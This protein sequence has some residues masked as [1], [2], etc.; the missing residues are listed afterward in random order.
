MEMELY[1]V[2]YIYEKIGKLFSKT[3]TKP[4]TWIQEFLDSVPSKSN[5]L[6]IG[7][8]NGRNMSG[9]RHNFTGVDNCNSFINICKK[10]GLNAI[11][12]DMTTLPFEDNTFDAI[13]S[14]ASFHH[15]ATAERRIAA[16]EEI[17]RVLKPGGRILLSVWSINQSHTK[18]LDFEYG[19]NF[20]PWK[21]K[22]GDNLGDRFYYIFK[23]QELNDLITKNTSMEIV[24]WSWDYGNEVIELAKF[25][26]LPSKK[27]YSIV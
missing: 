1:N 22:K 2:V 26:K 7:C 23:N 6:D 18:K 4:W 3:R 15:L 12:T 24:S 14:I 27:Q 10:K 11:K 13:I 17:N 16:L 5:I 8:G 25:D 19:D 9:S 21:N 20:V